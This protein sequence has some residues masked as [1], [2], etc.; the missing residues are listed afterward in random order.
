M[1]E[2]EKNKRK[3]W[4]AKVKAEIEMQVSEGRWKDAELRAKSEHEG[5]Q[6]NGY[7]L[8]LIYEKSKEI[9]IGN[10]IYKKD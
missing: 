1:T 9:Q 8:R 7:Q 10:T 3:A 5:T 2:L 4:K 6:P